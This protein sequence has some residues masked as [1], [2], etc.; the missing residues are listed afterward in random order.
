MLGK[1]TQTL[2]GL[3]SRLTCNR[4]HVTTMLPLHFSSTGTPTH[5]AYIL[6]SHA[7]TQYPVVYISLFICIV[8]T[9]CISSNSSSR[10]IEFAASEAWPTSLQLS[11][12]IQHC[13][14]VICK[15]S[16][17]HARSQLPWHQL[18]RY[19]ALNCNCRSYDTTTHQ[20]Q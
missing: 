3:T 16:S 20:F 7:A 5:V 9:L 15:N 1:A 17:T 10:H 2:K 14:P 13:T 19:T 11:I 12:V 4:W 6:T 18:A 8:S